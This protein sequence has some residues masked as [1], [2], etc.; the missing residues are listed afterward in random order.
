MNFSIE[1]AFPLLNNT[2][3]AIQQLLQQLDSDWLEV[4]EGPD[5]WNVKEIIA[6]L[7]VCEETDWMVRAA[8]IL[9]PDTSKQFTPIDRQAHF[10][11]SQQFSAEQL[12]SKF[13]RQREKNLSTLKKFNIQKSDYALTAVHPVL[14]AVCLQQLLSAW[15]VHDLTHLS[16]ISRVIA[17]LYTSEVGPFRQLLGVLNQKN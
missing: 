1:Q 7:L 8:I 13:K 3:K 9:L 16:Q 10:P 2:P 6:H 12:I 14:G 15:V 5:T 11:L 4:N 17:K